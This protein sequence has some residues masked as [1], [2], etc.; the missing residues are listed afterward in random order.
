MGEAVPI[1]DVAPLVSGVG[2]R[3]RVASDIRAACRRHGFFYVVG[4]DVPE[5]LVTR[6]E[7][8]S[9]AFFERPPEE[10]LEIAMERGGRAWRGFFPVGAE[11]TSGRPD[12]KEGLY[13]GEELGP[14]DPRVSSGTPLHGANLFPRE[15]AGLRDAVLD[16]MAALTRLAHTLL[17]GFAES[18]GLSAAYFAE[19]YTRDPLVLF[20][21][22]HYPPLPVEDAAGAREP[23]WSVGEH[24]DYGLL[25]ILRQTSPGLE[26]KVDGRWVAAPPIPGSF[27]CNLGDMLDRMTGGLYRSTPHRVR[28][29]T[30][31]SRY[32]FPFFFDPAFDAEIAP[33]FDAG[34]QG[35][36]SRWDGVD[37]HA[38]EGT[39]GDYLI[40]KVGRVFPGLG[41]DVL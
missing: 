40:R 2:A 30:G 17:E 21:I 20:R 25:T 36:A 37:V 38:F 18:L 33:V 27:V 4:H 5:S 19:R 15:P 41:R 3:E 24:T 39:Y 26:V 12:Q 10:K 32:S 1:V 22:F 28:N 6:L 31:G 14:E 16:Y 7:Q 29:R 9:R 11:L 35:G 23:L 8:E 34:P 13:F